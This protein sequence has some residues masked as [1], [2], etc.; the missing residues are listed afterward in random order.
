[1]LAHLPHMCRI[2][3]AHGVAVEAAA[4]IHDRLDFIAAC[5]ILVDLEADVACRLERCCICLSMLHKLR[6]GW[7]M[8]E[9][10]ASPLQ[11]FEDT[12]DTI[13]AAVLC[14]STEPT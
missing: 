7:C 4:S 14:F 11:L 3:L 10:L 9:K 5:H 12:S 2:D 6:H 13:S 8:F 1:M